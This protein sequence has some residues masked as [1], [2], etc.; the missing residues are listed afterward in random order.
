MNLSEFSLN[1]ILANLLILLGIN[2][3]NLIAIHAQTLTQRIELEDTSV[4]TLLL[5]EQYLDS[6][7]FNYCAPL[8]MTLNHTQQLKLTDHYEWQNKKLTTYQKSKAYYLSTPLSPEQTQIHLT[9]AIPIT[10]SSILL[11]DD[12][13]HTIISELSNVELLGAEKNLT[14]RQPLTVT[15]Q[16]PI[17][18]GTL[19]TNEF[20]I[21]PKGLYQFKYHDQ[22][23]LL[24][25]YIK[26]FEVL[27][28]KLT[29]RAEHNDSNINFQL[30]H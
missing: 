12:C 22:H 15:L 7:N 25:H 26:N 1:L 18:L 27:P 29:L 5:L 9:K 4:K 10:A 8:T 14:L 20:Y 2:W 30:K 6:S 19:N 3:I 28:Q 11:L 24:Q 23:V 13:Q 16:P 17:M 21:G